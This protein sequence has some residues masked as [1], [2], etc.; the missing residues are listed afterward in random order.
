LHCHSGCPGMAMRAWLLVCSSFVLP[1]QVVVVGRRRRVRLH[2]PHGCQLLWLPLAVAVRPP[3]FMDDPLTGACGGPRGMHERRR[4]CGDRL[5]PP[6]LPG[7]L[8]LLIVAASP[9]PLDAR[10]SSLLCCRLLPLIAG[11]PLCGCDAAAFAAWLL[12][13]HFGSSRNMWGLLSRAAQSLR[14]CLFSPFTALRAPCLGFGKRPM[15]G[16]AS[17]LPGAPAP[18]RAA[19]QEVERAEAASTEPANRPTQPAQLKAKAMAKAPRQHGRP[20]PRF[21]HHYCGGQ[22]PG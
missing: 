22:S 12:R 20:A 13:S 5:R 4:T 11:Y 19:D 16:A 14:R 15:A 17:T 3:P 7:W 8:S 6:A 21:C 2:V 1:C 9:P 10:S 18:A